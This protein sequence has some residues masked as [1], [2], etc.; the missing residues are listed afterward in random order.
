MCCTQ[1]QLNQ[2]FEKPLELVTTYRW[3]NLG[4]WVSFSKDQNSAA[5]T[6]GP[7][8][9]HLDFRRLFSIILFEFLR[10]CFNLLRV[11]WMGVLPN[12]VIN[13]R[14]RDVISSNDRPLTPSPCSD[15][16]FW[17]GDVMTSRPRKSATPQIHQH[18][19]HKRRHKSSQTV[20][21]TAGLYSPTHFR[22]ITAPPRTLDPGEGRI[23]HSKLCP[24]ARRKERIKSSTCWTYPRIGFRDG[25][26]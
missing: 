9:G 20:P 24:R 2:Y 5:F 7:T 13:W 8:K 10:K 16:D 6:K 3:V 18:F 15:E 23:T 26:L 17:G 25:A 11:F 4:L 22:R 21:P 12:D 14:Y 19:S 1:Y